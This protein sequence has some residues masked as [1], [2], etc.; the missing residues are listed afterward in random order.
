MTI[1]VRHLGTLSYEPCFAQMQAF[2]DARTADTPDELW[3]VEH[4]PVYTLGLAGDPKHLLKASE[5]PVVKT[6]RGGQITYHGP[7]QLVVYLLLDLRRR[8]LFVRAL[9]NQIEQA[10]IDAL[11]TYGIS[12]ARKPGAPGVYVQVDDAWAK[13]AA[14]GIKVRNQC[15]YH[16]LALNV[17]MDL[18]P[19]DNINPCGYEGLRTVDLGTLEIQS[20]LA[21]ASARLTAALQ[22]QLSQD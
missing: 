12:A 10:I 4:P 20:T 2:T 5:I 9:V 11:Q 16:G 13:I 7:G 14:L 21:E 15:T 8:R 18:T 6:D 22:K 17:N 19:F 1:L 3:I